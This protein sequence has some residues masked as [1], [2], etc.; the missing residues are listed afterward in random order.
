[1]RGV[2]GIEPRWQWWRRLIA[3]AIIVTSLHAGLVAYAYLQPPP[4]E[5]AEEPEG[6]FMMELAPLPVTA[7]TTPAEVSETI[8]DE[9]QP[10]IV[11]KTPTEEVPEVTPQKEELLP[12]APDPELAMPIAKPVE[13]P[14]EEKEEDKPPVEKKEVTE[15]KEEEPEVETAKPQEAMVQQ[16]TPSAPSSTT[17][18][19]TAARR[20]GTT[21]RQSNQTLTW[22]KAVVTHL[23]RHR[24]YP[25]GAR[26]SGHQGTAVVYFTIDRAGN[27][28][29]TRI[30]TSS[31]NA[32]L[33]AEAI[34]L[35]KRAAPF[36]LPPDT[37]PGEA[38]ELTI[39]VGF[40][41]N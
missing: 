9:T 28:L 7:A 19:K 10:K 23:G 29:T 25:A 12:V 27:L 32:L 40:T 26:K 6:A 13:E 11:E 2:N 31:K 4:E 5:E 14:K 33:D 20:Q 22:T 41:L 39:P 37:L 15:K 35:L 3:S 30:R 1:M 36:P 21:D 17:A 18:P 16:S 8:A 24:R 38:V 34:A